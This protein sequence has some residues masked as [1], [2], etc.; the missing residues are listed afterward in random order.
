V[1]PAAI[2][3]G[4][5][6]ARAIRARLRGR[7]LGAFHY[8][9]KGSLATIGRHAA[10]ADFRGLLFWGLPAWILWLVIHLVYLIE[11]ENR[12]LV[13]IQW[14]NNYITRHRG[15]RVITA[16]AGDDPPP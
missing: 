13:L 3:E 6:A 16:L 14:A 15:S 11:F 1:A 10:V 7:A 8:V 4:R 2:Q 9:D 5:Y 12:L